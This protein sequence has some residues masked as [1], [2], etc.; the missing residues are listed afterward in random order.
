MTTS[1]VIMFLN[2]LSK[3][4]DWIFCACVATHTLCSLYRNSQIGE[5]NFWTVANEFPPGEIKEKRYFSAGWL[6]FI[7]SPIQI[8]T[9]SWVLPV[10]C[11]WFTML[12]NRRHCCLFFFFLN[13]VIRDFKLKG[14]RTLSNMSL[15]EYL[16]MLPEKRVCKYANDAK[17]LEL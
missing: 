14:L 9:L 7:L 13:Q 16:H 15:V 10:G 2:L 6:Q 12:V 3:P 4:I 17:S 5:P 8:S 11:N 1:F